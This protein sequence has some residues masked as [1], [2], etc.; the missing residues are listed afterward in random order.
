MSPAV[1]WK[2]AR[3]YRTAAI[4]ITVVMVLI[5][6]MDLLI[7]PEYRD[8]LK[9]FQYPDAFKAFIG[10]AG[11]ITSP[12]GFLSA[13]FF[14]WV[15]LMT[16]TLAIIAGTGTLAGEEATGTLDLLLAQP[17]KRWR[18]VVSKGAGLAATLCLS[19]LACY[20]AFPLAKLF[21]DFPLSNARIAAGV[22]N[23]LPVTLLYLALSMALA[24]A[25]PSRGAASLAA[26]A[27]V[28][29]AY[30][31]NTIGAAAEVVEP[32]R[33]V[34]PFYWS[35]GSYVLIH[36]FPWL[37]A[38]GLLALAAALFGASLWFF[39]RRDIAV[40]PQDWKVRLHLRPGRGQAV[41]VAARE[42]ET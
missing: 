5:A 33:R 37:R 22:V 36:G 4:G 11:S 19:T 20:P 23:I 35:D 10:E 25:L 1:F 8:S 12:A 34:S 31:L 15:P 30:F 21:V 2:A 32:L 18:L 16:I 29:A 3:D 24:A 27:A 17:I 40:G 26:I 39:E 28:V 9:D 41:D 7:Y 14:S 13:E 6:I 38:L 42:L